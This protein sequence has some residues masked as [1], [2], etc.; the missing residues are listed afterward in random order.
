M[1][2]QIP[3]LEG[4]HCIYV[5][6]CSLLKSTPGKSVSEST[7]ITRYRREGGAQY[8]RLLQTGTPIAH[9]HV[10]IAQKAYFG[11]SFPTAT[12][13]ITD[14][15]KA[16]TTYKGCDVDLYFR[17]RYL[18]LAASLP[19][20]GLILA[21]QNKVLTKFEG[22]EVELAG[23]ELRL[24]NAPVDSIEWQVIDDVVF[25]DIIF[26]RPNSISDSY[27]SD[28]LEITHEALNVFVLGKA[29]PPRP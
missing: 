12:H 16:L 24:K 23:A 14:F 17:A 21:G 11:S 5:Q 9:V 29:K 25:V 28:S 18:V 3:A 15:R 2:V 20:T 26:Y 1:A 6:A 22:A 8:L 27:L 4:T 10:D 7:I 13:K 19:P